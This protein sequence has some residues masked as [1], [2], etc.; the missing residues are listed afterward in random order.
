MF[1]KRLFESSFDLLTENYESQ[2]GMSVYLEIIFR[3][4]HAWE[5]IIPVSVRYT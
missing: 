1:I 2:K 4:T 5:F 3:C